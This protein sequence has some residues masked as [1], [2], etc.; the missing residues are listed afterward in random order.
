MS[1]G[2]LRVAIAAL[3][4]AG[5]SIASYLAYTRYSGA[6]IAC[7][8]GGCETVQRSRYAELSGVP[9]AVL[10]LALYLGIL[11]TAL[12]PGELA[13]GAG[14]VLAVAGT[15]FADYLLVVQLAV[16]GAV[17]QWCVASDVLVTALAVLALVRFRRELPGAGVRMQERPT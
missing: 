3:A 11:V 5:A 8:T 12:R 6:P 16:I 7:S 14:A 15:L 17:C 2:R 10:G 13:A 4:L 9:V 1:D